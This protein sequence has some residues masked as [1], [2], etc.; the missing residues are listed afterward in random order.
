MRNIV[1]QPLR[2][3]EKSSA[4]ESGL[5]GEFEHMEGSE[6]LSAEYYDS[7]AADSLNHVS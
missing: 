4:D 6:Y 7:A 5:F 3:I 2:S 1:Y